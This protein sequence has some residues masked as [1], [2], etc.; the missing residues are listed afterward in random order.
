MVLARKFT[1][2]KWAKSEFID[3]DND[4]QADAITICLR[5]TNNS[6]SLW[7]Y[8]KDTDGHDNLTD[9]VY[10]F[11]CQQEKL[12]SIY[13]ILLEKEVIV[14]KGLNVEQTPGEA[15]LE[16]LK[17]QHFCVNN[18]TDKKLLSFAELM[19]TKY[20]N[21]SYSQFTPLELKNILLEKWENSTFSLNQL[22]RERQK[23]FYEPLI[24]H[25][26]SEK[27]SL[28]PEERGIKT[29]DIIRKIKD[30]PELDI[31]ILISNTIS[32]KPK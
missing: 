27:T 11:L 1:P 18:L 20:D 31:D 30:D 5:T 9:I 25:L 26:L 13:I 4:V 29:N 21:D 32:E 17:D 23:S 19:K 24:K 2:A 15:I 22:N 16:S 28:T 6:L 10:N 8:I 3:D 7:N 14:N 12:C